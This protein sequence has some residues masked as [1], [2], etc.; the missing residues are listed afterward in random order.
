VYP[1]T[2]FRVTCFP[3]GRK[4]I[5]F[6]SLRVIVDENWHPLRWWDLVS[7]IHQRRSVLCP[8]KRRLNRRH[9]QPGRSAGKYL[10]SLPEIK[11][12]FSGFPASKLFIIPTTLRDFL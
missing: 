10:V 11:P 1:S 3:P 5:W 2:S 12:W 9:Y 7:F 4:W 8:L 6:W